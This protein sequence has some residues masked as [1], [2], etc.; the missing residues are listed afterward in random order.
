M[1]LVAGQKPKWVVGLDHPALIRCLSLSCSVTT[2][3]LSSMELSVRDRDGKTVN[4]ARA[5]RLVRVMTESPDGILDAY[6]YWTRLSYDFLTEGNAIQTIVTAGNR[7]SS[8]RRM[9]P[10]NFQVYE[11]ADKIGVIYSLNRNVSGRSTSAPREYPHGEVIHSMWPLPE[12]DGQFRG[13]SPIQLINRS[14]K[15]ALMSDGYVEDFFKGG[16]SGAVRGRIAITVPPNATI[17]E[18]KEFLE[19]MEAASD[20]R[21]P[22]LL[23]EGMEMQSINDDPANEAMAKLREFQLREISRVYGLPA[24]LVGENVTQWGSGIEELAKLAWKFG[25]R[26]YVDSIL[27]PMSTRLLPYGE[28]LAINELELLRGDTLALTKLI[29]MMLNRKAMRISEARVLAVD[30]CRF[31]G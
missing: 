1:S 22:L 28:R 24:P 10:K 15:I 4:S 9:M 21:H 27:R 31:T 12:N 13:A 18:I 25:F 5:R 6:N 8:V 16:P 29:D 14:L 17:E 20:S 11:V 7:I 30:E 23:L 2:Q 26:H 19:N 3:L